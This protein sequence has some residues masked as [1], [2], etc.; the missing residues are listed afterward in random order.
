MTPPLVL[1]PDTVITRYHPKFPLEK[2]PPILPSPLP[3]IPKETVVS[4]KELILRAKG[5]VCA[6]SRDQQRDVA[7]PAKVNPTQKV[8]LNKLKGVSRALIEKVSQ[9]FHK[10]E[11]QKNN[12]NLPAI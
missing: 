7:Q 6:E 5:L 2:L 11:L 3:E 9:F 12:L 1:P 4:A 8:D 10:R